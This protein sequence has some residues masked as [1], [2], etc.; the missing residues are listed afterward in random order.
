MAITKKQQK[1]LEALAAMP[2]NQID[3]SDIPEIAD[4]SGGVRGMFSRP[5]T[6]HI[7]IRLNASG[8]GDRK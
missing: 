2:D 6:K 3:F 5:E 8:S 4:F 1:E 7:S